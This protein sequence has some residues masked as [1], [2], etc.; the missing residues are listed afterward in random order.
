MISKNSAHEKSVNFI[1]SKHDNDEDY[2]IHL[3]SDN[4]EIMNNDEADEVIINS[5]KKRYLNT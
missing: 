3:K 2:I 5:P 1:S 4:I